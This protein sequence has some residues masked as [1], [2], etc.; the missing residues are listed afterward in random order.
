MEAMLANA[1]GGSLLTKAF[2]PI[3]Q[4]AMGFMQA[5]G[6][7]ER[8]KVNSYIGKTRAI[9]TDTASRQGLNDEMGEIRNVLGANGQPQGVGT[10][11]VMDELRRTRDRERRINVGN[12]MSEAADWRL[13]GKNAGM[14][15]FGSL[16]GGLIRSGPSLFDY[17]EYRSKQG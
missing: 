17:Y 7:Q 6:E 3:A 10:M 8:A 11:E 9:Q 1:V 13:Q 12:R 16:A 15:A 14:K 2:I 5:K 4:G